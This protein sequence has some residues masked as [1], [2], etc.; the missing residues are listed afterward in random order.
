MCDLK[1][2]FTIGHSNRS[3]EDF[4]SLLM[5][6]GIQILVDVRRFPTSKHE[7]F[8]RENLEK[9]LEK[10]GIKYIYL[11]DKLGGYRSGGYKSFTQTEE[12]RRGIEH[13]EEIAKTGVTAIMCAERFPWRC[14][15]KYISITL[16]E[17]GWEIVHIID[18][19]RVWRPKRSRT[20]ESGQ[21]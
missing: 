19:G 20:A 17:K 12:F 4:I 6:H 2:I 7:H 9:Y 8:K 18:K 3:I 11:G 13:L 15:R 10:Y 21:M 5:K 1:K 14:H 16:E